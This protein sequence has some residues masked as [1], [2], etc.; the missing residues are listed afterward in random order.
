MLIVLAIL[1]IL[2]ALLVVAAQKARASMA[3]VECANNLKQIGIALYSYHAAHSCFP[4]ALG[5]PVAGAAIAPARPVLPM[6]TAE[7]TWIRSILPHLDQQHPAWDEVLTV[8]ACPA[9]PRGK[10]LYNSYDGHGYTCYLAVAGWENYDSLGIMFLNSRIRAEDVSDGTSNTLLVAERPPAIMGTQQGWGW[11]E[12]AD[13]G[14]VSIGLKVTKWYQHTNCIVTPQY[15]GT[16]A[17]AVNDA[18]FLGDSTF[19]HA[20]HP[21]SFHAGGAN[22]LLGDGSVRFVAYS[23]GRILPA[24]ATIRG[25]E[26]VGLPQ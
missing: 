14:D 1:G 10:R 23:A 26:T 9:D 18:G 16:G 12:S 19:C 2:M 15:F 25:G 24:L 21:W 17:S 8:L 20:N 22:M 4:A 5:P 6:A 11:W 3:R 13:V 7:A